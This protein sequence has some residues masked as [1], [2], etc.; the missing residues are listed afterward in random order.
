MTTAWM[1]MVLVSGQV[2]AGGSSSTSQARVKDCLVS[3]IDDVQ[4]SS[5]DSGLI[6]S[7]EVREGDQVRHGDQLGTIN[8]RQAQA[9]KRIAVAEHAAAREKAENDINV[10]YASKACDVAKKEYESSADANRKV[11]GTKSYIELEKLRLT[12]EQASLQ[13]EQSQHDQAVAKY[14]SDARAA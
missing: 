14:D 2:S 1:V 12:V 3:L 11:S 4:L 7:V 6:V 8:D 5:E 13:I 9:A 10:R